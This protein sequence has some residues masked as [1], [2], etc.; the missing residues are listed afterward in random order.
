MLIFVNSLIVYAADNQTSSK[1]VNKEK[2]FS[3]LYNESKSDN[4][5]SEAHIVSWVIL[6][7]KN[8]KNYD[9]SQALDKLEDM[10]D[11]SN[12]DDDVYETSMAIIALKKTGNNVDNEI[13]WL[14]DQQE[15]VLESGDWLVQFLTNSEDAQCNI[16]YDDDTYEF[17]INKTK[18]V[19]SSESC[20]V[21]DNYWVDFEECVKDDNADMYETF[22]VECLSNSNVKTSI[23]F[24]NDNT[25]YITDQNEPLEIENSCFYGNGNDCSCLSTQYASWAFSVVNDPEYRSYTLPYLRSSCNEEILDNIFLY[26]LTSSNEYYSYLASDDGQLEDGSFSGDEYQTA[27]ALI[28]MKGKSSPEVTK[29]VNWLAFKQRQDGSWNGNIRTT[30][31]VLYALTADVSV[32][33]TVTNTTGCGDRRFDNATE[34]CEYASNCN[35]SSME[36][37]SLCQCVA[38]SG[39][40]RDEDCVALGS[41]FVCNNGLCESDRCNCGIGEICI[42]GVC[43]PEQTQDKCI[44]DLDCP[45]DEVCISGVCVL[46]E[47]S[48]WVTWLIVI[49][50]VLVGLAG[51]YFGYKKFFR[52]Q[53]KVKPSGF[54]PNNQFAPRD[55]PQTKQNVP[56]INNQPVSNSVDKMEEQLDQSLKKARDLLR[57]K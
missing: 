30:A 5:G 19:D 34:Q 43:K 28:A 7:L 50:I 56:V 9:Y 37:N 52:K 24:K 40:T 22:D 51:A 42:N 12:W 39:C 31:A 54:K 55:Y 35:N 33:P 48:S 14:N 2:A 6:A 25:Y 21:I 26:M 16:N 27:L 17:T 29:A 53:G 57:G 20:G 46:E 3:W 38:K 41:T 10:E 1:A 44:D 49:L 11:D 47:G 23:L 13:E 15:E 4:W 32:G 8:N 36:C 45:G 18:I